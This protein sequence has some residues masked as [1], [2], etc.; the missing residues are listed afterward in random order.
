MSA[1]I[2]A[3]REKRGHGELADLLAGSDTWQVG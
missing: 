3:A 1:Q 2:D